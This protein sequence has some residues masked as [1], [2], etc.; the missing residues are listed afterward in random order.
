[1]PP[2]AP[3]SPPMPMIEAMACLGNMSETVVYKFADHA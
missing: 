1:M 2:A 3:A